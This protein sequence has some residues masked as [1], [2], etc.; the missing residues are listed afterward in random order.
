MQRVDDVALALAHLLTL[1]VTYKSMD[2]N[3][4][5]GDIFHELQPHHHH[6]GNPEEK[7]IEAGDQARGRV[8]LGQAL[9]LLRPPH[10]G[11]RP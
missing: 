8:E 6:A 2:I 4:L 1:G 3:I 11:E 9:S 7:D 10:G 5:E